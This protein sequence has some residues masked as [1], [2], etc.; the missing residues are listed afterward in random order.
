MLKSV[1]VNFLIGQSAVRGRVVRVFDEFH[2]EFVCGEVFVHRIPLHVV[3]ADDTDLDDFNVRLRVI[4]AP[5]Q[6]EGEN[7]GRREQKNGF[8]EL[9]RHD[10]IPAN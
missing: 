1:Q 5:R 3:F 2:A 4:P 7:A 6:S 8:F 9:D 10:E